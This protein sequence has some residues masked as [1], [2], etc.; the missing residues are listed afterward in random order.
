M[1]AIIDSEHFSTL[2]STSASAPA[3]APAPAPAKKATPLPPLYIRA[4]EEKIN[5]EKRRHCVRRVYRRIPHSGEMV[6][7][8]D[9]NY[10]DVQA[11]VHDIA[12]KISEYIRIQHY[13]DNEGSESH[14]FSPLVRLAINLF[15]EWG[16][17]P[18][19]E[20]ALRTMVA[21]AKTI[22]LTKPYTIV[23]PANPAAFDA[24]SNECTTSEADAKAAVLGGCKK[25]YV[26]T[27][28][29]LAELN[30]FTMMGD[31][32][33]YK[34]RIFKKLKKMVKSNDDFQK[35]MLYSYIYGRYPK[36]RPTM[37]Q[38]I[39]KLKGLLFFEGVEGWMNLHDPS[40]KDYVCEVEYDEDYDDYV[41]GYGEYYDEYDEDD[42]EYYDEY[43]E[44][45]HEY[46]EDDETRRISR[47][48]LAAAREE[49]ERKRKFLAAARAE[50]ERK[51]KFLAAAENFYAKPPKGTQPTTIYWNEHIIRQYN[52]PALMEARAR[53][54]VDEVLEDLQ[55]KF[56]LL[57]VLYTWLEP[58]YY[59]SAAYVHTYEVTP[60]SDPFTP[61]TRKFLESRPMTQDEIVL[62][63]RGKL[64]DTPE[65]NYWYHYCSGCFGTSNGL[66]PARFAKKE[67]VP[68]PPNRTA[69]KKP[70]QEARANLPADWEKILNGITY[71]V[72]HYGS[73]SA[74]A[75]RHSA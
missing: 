32:S 15:I 68:L 28:F 62:A 75:S 74:S 73:R 20:G 24:A 37:E 57:D 69:E 9:D 40:I 21:A 54:A 17:K 29:L 10:Q 56:Q 48:A 16:L 46:Y 65:L 42:R 41:N 22:R 66:H 36:A 60:S 34:E 49:E 14:S 44:D 6:S 71:K 39:A 38:F 47:E 59:L 13:L 1:S 19:N 53:Q 50:E 3:S 55:T 26:E 31:L 8:V 2:A 30:R 51:R 4:M 33:A 72:S 27:S 67:N 5:S 64:K 61:P 18:E 23:D 58:P 11:E 52:L 43:D 63:Y 45:D 7:D 35:S 12:R 70:I 25:V